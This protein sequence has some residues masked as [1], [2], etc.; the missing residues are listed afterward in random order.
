MVKTRNESRPYTN[1]YGT[2]RLPSTKGS[3]W[4]GHNK[5][6]RKERPKPNLKKIV[7]LTL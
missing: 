6:P 1:E 4:M 3:P 7:L 2:I 5:I